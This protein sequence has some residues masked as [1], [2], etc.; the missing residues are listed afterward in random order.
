ML[1][2]F[3]FA[4]ALAAAP[5]DRPKLP[6]ELEQ[7]VQLAN[8]SP[9]EF[10]ADALLRVASIPKIDTR[11][12]KELIERA[13]HLAPGA[14]FRTPL[15]GAGP[16]ADT[17]SGMMVEA[18]RLNLDTLTLQ[19]RAIRSMLE[20]DKKAARDLFLEINQPVLDR[21]CDQA[22]VPNAGPLYDVLAAVVNTTFTDQERKKEA[23][24]NL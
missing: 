22:L 19:A 5:V 8:A 3:L 15:T 23:H 10:A 13:F 2:F 1:R 12:R 11:L 6:Q 9:P 4:L 21:N 14:Q 24:L 16:L 7:L 17:R 18:A 20:L